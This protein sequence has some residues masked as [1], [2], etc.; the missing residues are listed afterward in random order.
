M[1]AL[2]FLSRELTKEKTTNPEKSRFFGVFFIFLQEKIFCKCSVTQ[3]KEG[4]SLPVFVFLVFN[5]ESFT[6]QQ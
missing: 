4:H 3:K 5:P 1:Q 6:E 2:I